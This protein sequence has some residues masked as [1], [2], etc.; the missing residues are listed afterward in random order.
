MFIGH[1]FLQFL[2]FMY[3]RQMLS[4]SLKVKIRKGNR[5]TCF[6]VRCHYMGLPPCLKYRSW[7]GRYGGSGSHSKCSN[8]S[9][10]QFLFSS[11]IELLVY[12]TSR[13]IAVTDDP[14]SMLALMRLL[15]KR[16]RYKS[17]ICQHPLISI[18]SRRGHIQSRFDI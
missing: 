7:S 18:D 16:R 8:F 10:N 13:L 11:L 9:V 3:S 17:E 2:L 1:R 15:T 14:G 5:R 12:T 6:R 4:A